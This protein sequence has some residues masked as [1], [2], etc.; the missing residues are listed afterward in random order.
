[1]I[2]EIQTVVEKQFVELFNQ[3]HWNFHINSQIFFRI[4]KSSDLIFS[5]L[6]RPYITHFV[7][8]V[9]NFNVSS[10]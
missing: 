2:L 9:K 5:G 7:N 8:E 10:R 6:D 1:M 4:V 3:G